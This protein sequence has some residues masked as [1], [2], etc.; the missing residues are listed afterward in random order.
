MGNI[1]DHQTM[2][3][4]RVNEPKGTS[5]SNQERWEEK[6]RHYQWEIT[7]Y[8][9]ESEGSTDYAGMVYGDD[10]MED[11]PRITRNELIAMCKRRI[12]EYQGYLALEQSYH[13][14]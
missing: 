1:P 6:I 13:S 9:A 4:F 2:C 3:A 7:V 8:E 14:A 12:A 11:A 10:R 5:V